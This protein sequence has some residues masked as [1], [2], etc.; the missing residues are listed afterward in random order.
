MWAIFS[1]GVLESRL[2]EM[3]VPCSVPTRNLVGW[4]WEA[5]GSSC[6]QDGDPMVGVLLQP[7]PWDP[8]HWGVQ[9]PKCQQD[10]VFLEHINSQFF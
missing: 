9:G 7:E 4:G 6:Q 2:Q 1:G 10:P 3:M 5:G 8:H